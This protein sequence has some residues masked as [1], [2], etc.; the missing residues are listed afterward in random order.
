MDGV[1]GGGPRTRQVPPVECRL[2]G[3]LTE[4]TMI[5]RSWTCSRAARTWA[6]SAIGLGALIITPNAGAGD[7]LPCCDLTGDLLIGLDD[8]SLLLA[9]FGCSGDCVGD[10]DQDGD[11]DVGDLALLLSAFG[12]HCQPDLVITDGAA[13]SNVSLCTTF[14]VDYRVANC[15]S[16]QVADASAIAL[17]LSSDARL[18]RG[19]DVLLAQHSLAAGLRP[20]DSLAG[21]FDNVS[22]PAETPGGPGF[23]LIVADPDGTVAE[24]SETN[25]CLPF[26]IVIAAPGHDIGIESLSFS[27]P[28]DSGDSVPVTV[29]LVNS[30]VFAET[31]RL[32]VCINSSCHDCDVLVPACGQAI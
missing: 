22:L 27:S 28:V 3:R 5:P 4:R 8:L 20:G 12:K 26:P 9:N 15:G 24:L 30:D 23:L 6:A 19:T 11:V 14:A 17:F 18:D 29:R 16:W 25:N 1:S 13:P 7:A 32:T 2:A 31:V 10:F 21:R